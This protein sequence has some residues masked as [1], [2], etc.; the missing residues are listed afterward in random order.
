MHH[1]AST[2]FLWLCLFDKRPIYSSDFCLKSIVSNIH[3]F[4]AEGADLPVVKDDMESMEYPLFALKTGDTRIIQWKKEIKCPLGSKTI[5]QTSILPLAH[6]GRATIFDKDIWIF[7]ISKLMKAKLNR[8]KI[9]RFVEFTAMEYFRGTN[10][11]L[12]SKQ[13]EL[14]QNALNRLS[15]TKIE[16]YKQVYDM[17]EK[18]TEETTENMSLL[19]SWMIT[20]EGKNNLPLK[21]LVELPLWLYNSVLTNQVLTISPDYFRLRKSMDRRIYEIARKFCGKQ[22]Q[23]KIGLGRLREKVG[24]K[25]DLR[26]FRNEFKSLVE[27]NVL[28]DF[29]V[30]Y[31][32][33]TD[34]ATFKNKKFIKQI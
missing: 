19:D 32:K 1:T 14:F 30:V 29:D 11:S 15:G 22:E 18:L 23:F 7:I 9:N 16:I 3:T 28:P 26:H 21:V 17:N 4:I 27:A 31:D 24:T 25:V 12:S 34:I 13:Y 2:A 5:I 10:K 33:N 20:K 6:Y 8:E